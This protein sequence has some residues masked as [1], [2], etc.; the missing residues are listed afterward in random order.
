MRFYKNGQ[1]IASHP[2]VDD[3]VINYM[4]INHDF[5]LVLFGE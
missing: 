3:G 4:R 2:S 1:L 5:D